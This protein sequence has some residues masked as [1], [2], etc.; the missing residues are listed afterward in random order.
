MEGQE[1]E[2]VNTEKE[3]VGRISISLCVESAGR[4]TLKKIIYFNWRLIIL[5]YGGC[6]CHTLT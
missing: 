1:E 2:L 3:E 5:K 6:F 4:A